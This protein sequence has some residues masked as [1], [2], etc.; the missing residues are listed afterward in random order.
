MKYCRQYMHKM[1]MKI[2]VHFKN[3]VLKGFLIFALNRKFH[4]FH[5]FILCLPVEGKYNYALLW[6]GGGGLG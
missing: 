4:S 3:T 5:I 2:L 1:Y 6:G